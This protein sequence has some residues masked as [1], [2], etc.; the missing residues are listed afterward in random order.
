[1]K[2]QVLV[3][4]CLLVLAVP[5]LAQ[6]VAVI[7]GLEVTVV[8]EA[9]GDKETVA[10]EP[11]AKEETFLTPETDST[12][13]GSV[14]QV[15]L[16]AEETAGN[17]P[18]ES[19]PLTIEEVDVISPVEATPLLPSAQLSEAKQLIAAGELSGAKKILKATL[20]NLKGDNYDKAQDLLAEVNNKLLFQF[21][22]DFPG[23]TIHQVKPGESLYVI[24]KKYKT[25]PEF[26]AV[27]NGIKGTVIHPNQKL[28]VITAPILIHVSKSKNRMEV[29]VDKEIIRIY[30][31]ATGLNNSSPIGA[32]T[33][34]TKVENPT[35]Y[36]TGAIVPP[37]NKENILGT[38][39]L[40]F[41]LA[42]FGIHG[43][44]LP[45]SIGTQS[46]AGCVRMLNKDVEELYA[47]VPLN[48]QVTVVD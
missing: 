33:I 22:S 21:D 28:R 19:A 25:T 26:I 10:E 30:P 20:V 34:V 41:S 9:S 27:L 42:G 47:M 4:V 23:V 14:L 35:W 40:G 18:V 29:Y 7:E 37:G 2:I 8:D 44:T 15:S 43:T 32:F 46:T 6:E 1:M 24:A 45:E 12:G 48:A 16:E 3:L 13:K 36:K 31:V 5:A 17:A 11:A 39:W 38:R